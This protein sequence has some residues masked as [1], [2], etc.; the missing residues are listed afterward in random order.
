[1]KKNVKLDMTQI[2]EALQKLSFLKSY[3]FLLPSVII[4]IVAILVY[5]PTP[6]MNSNLQQ[7]IQKESVS[8]GNSLA[9]LGKEIVSKDQWIQEEKSSLAYLSDVEKASGLALQASQRE[10]LSYNMF[11]APK[12]TSV[13]IFKQFGQTFQTKLE[14]L[15]KAAGGGDRPTDNELGL[16]SGSGRTSGR[17]AA[18]S[19]GQISDKVRN[20][21][22]L[23]R[24]QAI[25]FYVSVY[26]LMFYNYWSSNNSN[27]GQKQGNV[28]DYSGV[29]SAAEACWYTQIGYWIIEDVIA[30]I[31]AVNSSSSNGVYTSAVKRLIDF[32]FGLT[33][34][35]QSISGA[36]VLPEYVISSRDSYG[37]RSQNAGPVTLTGH[38]S[39]DG[40]DVVYFNMS[41]AI[42]SVKM[43][44]F[45]KELCSAKKHSFAG[46]DGQAANRNFKH[47]QITILDA[48]FEIIDRN[49][50][51]NKYYRY[52]DAA[53]VE[54]VISCEYVFNKKGYFDIKPA[55]I[56]MLLN[57]ELETGNVQNEREAPGFRPGND[58]QTI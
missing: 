45:M 58:G 9:N 17:N 24:A 11:P 20:A 54:L 3:S 31:K 1:M 40:I 26:D 36:K 47:N 10:L 30:T 50:V 48:D 7:K 27:T 46:F 12:D 32:N 13:T 4:I 57:E 37:G 55:T 21:L 14:D 43:M 53:V 38:S 56:K 5:L 16:S 2:K 23:K 51:E 42:D 41:L 28:F 8:K 29:D 39:K 49:A 22:C 35:S 15:V 25:S 52:G 18:R 34:D 19:T 6:I 33:G 44:E